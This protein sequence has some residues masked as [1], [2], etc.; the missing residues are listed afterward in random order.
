MKTELKALVCG[1][2]DFSDEAHL[3]SVL[4]SFTFEGKKIDSLISGLARGAD[5]L[6]EKW[7]RANNI[8]FEGYP[9]DWKQYG[10]SAGPIRNKQM[11]DEGKPDVVIAFPGGRGT[12]NMINQARA[13]GVPTITI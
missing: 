4:S 9:A 1:G 10:R 8:P 7:A 5:S 3:F 2:R 6:A 12:S 13:R 11:L